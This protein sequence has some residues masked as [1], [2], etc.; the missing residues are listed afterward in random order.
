M[1]DLTRTFGGLIIMAH[2][3]NRQT[4]FKIPSIYTYIIR[5]LYFP[6]FSYIFL[7]FP[8]Y[9]FSY[10]F[11]YFPIFSYIYFPIF[12]YIKARVLAARCS[13]PGTAYVCSAAM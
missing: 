4:L 8:I 2:R 12:S 5:F 11:L 9:I 3:V 7:Y 10:I 13:L 6:I 1:G